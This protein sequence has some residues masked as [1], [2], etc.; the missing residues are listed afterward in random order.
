MAKKKDNKYKVLS[1][2]EM[3][4]LENTINE[5]KNTNRK[6]LLIT[7]GY[8]NRMYRVLDIKDNLYLLNRDSEHI[9]FD[10]ENKEAKSY[11]SIF[12]NKITTNNI[13]W[14]DFIKEP[15]KPKKELVKKTVKKR[16]TT[17]TTKV[18]TTKKTTSKKGNTK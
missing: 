9:I 2:P 13:P 4:W 12:S 14:S 17:A 18:T 11:G 3:T 16:T 8:G 10:L 15:E 1:L 5:F 6:I 7:L